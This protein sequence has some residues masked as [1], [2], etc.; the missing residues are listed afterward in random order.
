MN[1][2][3]FLWFGTVLV[4]SLLIAC[5]PENEKDNNTSV[6][7]QL[8]VGAV[9]GTNALAALVRQ[10]GQIAFYVC[11]HGDTLQSHTRWFNGEMVVDQDGFEL[12]SEAWESTGTVA[13][14]TATGS[15]RDP[16]GMSHAWTLHAAPKGS[17]ANLYSVMHSGCRTGVIVLDDGK[18]EEPAVQGGWCNGEGLIKQVTPMLPLA[19]T[20]EGLEISVDLDTGP[21]SFFVQPHEIPY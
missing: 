9:E 3:Q 17:L 1:R 14:D 21:E 8:F 2:H 20:S 6:D 10:N 15:L 4:I 13:G 12:A 11:G 7:R 18:T 16:D 19:L 5:G